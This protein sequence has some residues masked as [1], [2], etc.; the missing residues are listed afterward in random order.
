MSS[1]LRSDGAR[2]FLKKYFVDEKASKRG[3]SKF[4]EKLKNFVDEVPAAETR[5][6]FLFLVLFENLVLKFLG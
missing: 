6:I 4:Y 3:F 1:N 2:L 5:L